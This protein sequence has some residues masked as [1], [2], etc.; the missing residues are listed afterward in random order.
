MVDTGT[1]AQ[2]FRAKG[3]T[4][5]PKMAFRTT[6]TK[7]LPVRLESPQMEAPVMTKAKT[8]RTFGHLGIYLDSA[9]FCPDSDERQ[10]ALSL[11]TSAIRTVRKVSDSSPG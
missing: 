4:L 11:S 9:A 5:M 8:L 2:L 1:L 10:A 6:R 7:F 3:V